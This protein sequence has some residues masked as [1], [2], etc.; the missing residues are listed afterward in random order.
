[1]VAL[2]LALPGCGGGDD[3]ADTAPAEESTTA[4][5]E[6]V[7]K[8]LDQKPRIEV[9]EEPPP[10]SLEVDDIVEGD[11][12]TAESGDRLQ[13]DYVGVAYSTGGEFDSSWGAKPLTFELGSGRVIPGWDQG[14][15]G[16]K[17]GGRRQ[18]TIPPELAYGPEGVPPDI[19]PN[20]TLIFVVDLLDVKD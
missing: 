11:G 5:S 14:L 9:P 20:E 19:G 6:L 18:L 7:S 16:M 13:V 10:P 4:P 17:V 8:D 15:E 3:G 2:A 12:P 1:M